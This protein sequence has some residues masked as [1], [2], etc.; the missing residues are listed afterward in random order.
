MEEFDSAQNFWKG[1]DKTWC[2]MAHVFVR[3]IERVWRGY[4]AE[5]FYV[6]YFAWW[7]VLSLHAHR[8]GRVKFN[9]NHVFDRTAY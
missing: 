9:V 1:G 6:Y 7:N 5:L 4:F 3:K 8:A 2:R